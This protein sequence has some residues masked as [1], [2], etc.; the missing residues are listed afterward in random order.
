MSH[1]GCR[2]V[3]VESVL[4]PLDLDPY[5]KIGWIRNPEKQE[6]SKTENNSGAFCRWYLRARVEAAAPPLRQAGKL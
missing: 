5:K 3:S 2:S 1:S 4:F 6:T